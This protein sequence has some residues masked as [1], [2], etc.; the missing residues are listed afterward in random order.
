M[1]RC[2]G[3]LVSPRDVQCAVIGYRR[4]GKQ[5]MRGGGAEGSPEVMCPLYCS[6]K[7]SAINHRVGGRLEKKDED[8]KDRKR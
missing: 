5:V 7:D 6:C 2:V 3:A 8:T 4:A 1:K